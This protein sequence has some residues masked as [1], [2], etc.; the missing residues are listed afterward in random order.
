MP[1]TKRPLW[2]GWSSAERPGDRRAVRRNGSEITRPEGAKPFSNHGW[3]GAVGSRQQTQ[4]AKRM[5]V[6]AASRIL[7]AGIREMRAISFTTEIVAR[8]ALHAGSR[9]FVPC[10]LPAAGVSV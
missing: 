1:S 5:A 2:S 3:Q 8:Y 10:R 7:G 9:F 6:S 4:S